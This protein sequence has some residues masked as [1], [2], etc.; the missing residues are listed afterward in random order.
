MADP[1]PSK[2]LCSQLR[3]LSGGNRLLGYT[4]AEEIERLQREL[5]RMTS[6]AGTVLPQL[7]DA[8]MRAAPE[9]EPTHF[10]FLIKRP[11]DKEAWPTIFSS[12][13]GAEGYEHRVSEVVPVC[14]AQPPR[15]GQ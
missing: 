12:R 15:D 9:T 5:D 10:A 11:R 7:H 6:L 3:A 4:A 2:D 8:V 13:E 1:V 14:L